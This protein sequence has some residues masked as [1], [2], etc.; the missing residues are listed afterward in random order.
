VRPVFEHR[1]G[2]R[3]ATMTMPRSSLESFPSFDGIRIAYFDK[4]EGPAVILLHGHAAD[5]RMFGPVDDLRHEL[6]AIKAS[7]GELG[8]DTSFDFPEDGR[9]GLRDRLL[10]AGARVIVPDLRGHG[11]S[12][13]PHDPEAYAHSAMAR[14]AIAL[15]DHLR[16]DDFS[17]LGYSLGAIATAKLLALRPPN[18]TAAILGGICQEILEGELLEIPQTHP[19]AR[20][21]RRVTMRAYMEYVA[22]TLLLEDASPRDPGA[23]YRIVAQAMGNDVE[24]LAAVLRGDGSEPVSVAALHAFTAPVLLLNGR[25]DPA[26]LATARLAEVLPNARVAICEGDH[27]SAPWQPSFQQAVVKFLAKELAGGVSASRT[28]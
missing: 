27:L 15:A 18:V 1:D 17:I 5:S 4:G 10:E 14:D 24:A 11:H 13:K 16:L 25:N 6:D 2:H 22:D 7:I 28:G 26:H 21:G 8:V 9:R 19:A 20:L 23:S 12:D 3:E